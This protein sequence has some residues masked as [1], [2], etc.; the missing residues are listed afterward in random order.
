MQ[1]KNTSRVSLDDVAKEVGLTRLLK[2]NVIVMVSTGDIGAEARRY[3]NKI[4][5]ESNL[6]IVM[7][8]R[9]DL[10]MIRANPAHVV[11]AF[12]RE[13][14]HAMNLKKMEI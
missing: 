8:D 12:G 14:S 3:A 5:A 13:S 1:C 4:M 9:A 7:I 11:E 6:C 10:K 2:S